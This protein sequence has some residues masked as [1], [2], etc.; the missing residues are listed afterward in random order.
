RGPTRPSQGWQAH[1]EAAYTLHQFT[2]D[3]EQRQA[4]CPQGKVS[5]VWRE[6]SDREGKPY[7]IV[8]FSLQDCGPCPARSL[9]FRT[10]EAG[11]RQQYR[12]PGRVARRAPAGQDAHLSFRRAR[13]RLRPTLGDTT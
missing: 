5:T 12:P 3:W 4:P 11:R 6:Y 1:T 9:C 2:V 10:T 7:T 13:S 8:R